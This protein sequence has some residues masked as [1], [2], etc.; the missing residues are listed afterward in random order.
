MISWLIRL[1]LV[2]Q[3]PAHD[4]V[5]RDVHLRTVDADGHCPLTGGDEL[6][7]E[8]LAPFDLA[9]RADGDAAADDVLEV[10]A[11]A[12]RPLQTGGRDVD[13]VPVEVAA[14]HVRDALAERMVDPLRV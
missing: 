11:L 5:V 3:I 1:P 13:R 9:G 14:Q 4:V 10:R 12:Q 6:A 8:P 2:D 7:A